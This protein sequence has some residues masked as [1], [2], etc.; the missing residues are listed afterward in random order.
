MAEVT[1][2]R[3]QEALGASSVGNTLS[4]RK[5]SPGEA[6]AGDTLWRRECPAVP[7]TASLGSPAKAYM[8]DSGRISRVKLSGSP[9]AI[10]EP[11][12]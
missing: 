11:Y 2:S 10:P 8:R 5:M 6:A 7:A 4:A 9:F 3:L 1:H 12:L